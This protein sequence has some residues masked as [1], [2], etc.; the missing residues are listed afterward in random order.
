[1]DQF[2]F[3]GTVDVFS[4]SIVIGVTD[5]AG[6]SCNAVLGKSL[7]VD[8][9]DILRPVIRM[10]HQTCC[11]LSTH[12]R[13]VERLQRQSLKSAWNLITPTQRSAWSKRR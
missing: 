3:V 12:D 5:T 10:V 1:M 9:A 8:H 11:F 4:Q 13:L 6:G 7:V 2:V